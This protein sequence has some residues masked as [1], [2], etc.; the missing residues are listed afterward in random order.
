MINGCELTEVDVLKGPSL[1]PATPV[2]QWA[3]IP[4]GVDIDTSTL[5]TGGVPR[6][7][8][9]ALS[10]PCVLKSGET[11]WSAKRRLSAM[12]QGQRVDVGFAEYPGWHVTGRVALSGWSWPGK[13]T[14]AILF[15]LTVDAEPYWYKDTLTTVVVAASTKGTS[16]SLSPTGYSVMP[17]A[18]V[19]GSAV[20]LVQGGTRTSL[21]VGVTSW[22][23]GLR[24]DPVVAGGSPSPAVGTIMGADTAKVTFTWREGWPG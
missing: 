14:Q 11:L 12:L 3:P 20:T 13:S 5:L 1:D 15:T 2:T 24:L 22:L 10:L 6:F 7:A 18:T 17:V 23:D 19:T 4:G 8:R 21:P 9:A 16:F